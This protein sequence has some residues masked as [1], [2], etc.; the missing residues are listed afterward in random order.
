MIRLPLMIDAS[1]SEAQA[2]ERKEKFFKKQLD[3]TQ[4]CCRMRGLG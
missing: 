3:E 4:G 2:V 1:R